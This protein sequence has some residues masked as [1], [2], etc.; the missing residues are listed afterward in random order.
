M[1][2]FLAHSSWAQPSLY[3]RKL[4]TEAEIGATEQ[5]VAAEIARRT[6]PLKQGRPEILALDGRPIDVLEGINRELAKPILDASKRAVMARVEELSKKWVTA[7][8]EEARLRFEENKK[9]G[10]NAQL[11]YDA[12]GIPETELLRANHELAVKALKAAKGKPGV[13]ELEASVAQLAIEALKKSFNARVKAAADE[14]M[15]AAEEKLAES[16]NKILPDWDS[17]VNATSPIVAEFAAQLAR[18]FP[19]ERAQAKKSKSAVEASAVAAEKLPAPVTAQLNPAGVPELVV[20]EIGVRAYYD[21]ELGTVV[22]EST[23]GLMP[24]PDGPVMVVDHGDGT[25]KSNASSW[26]YVLAKF[27]DS[28]WNPIAMNLPKAGV[29]MDITGFYKT[30]AYLDHRYRVVRARTTP[31]DGSAAMPIVL[32]GRSMG[33]AKGYAHALLYDGPANVVDA[34]VLSSFSNPYTMDLQITNV[35]KQVA[36]GNIKG[37]VPEMLEGAKVL[38]QEMLAA[39]EKLKTDDPA[40]FKDFGDNQFYLQGNA[41]E[42][43][44]PSVLVDLKQFTDNFA[45]R[46]HT[47]V[48]ENALL[49]YEIP[50]FAK[51][52]PAQWEGTHNLFS[53][54]QNLTPESLKRSVDGMKARKASGAPGPVLRGRRRDVRFFRLPGHEYVVTP[55]DDPRQKEFPGAAREAHGRQVV[56]G[57]VSREDEDHAGRAA[58]GQGRALFSCRAPE[59]RR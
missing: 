4:L 26:K 13:G 42:D 16:V 8:K 1:A 19:I 43:G 22:L 20:G 33:S 57:V 47:Y 18:D 52:D 3:C 55:R 30:T 51:I 34:Y 32:M 7:S 37:V 38:S 11:T 50:N 48:F 56:P 44:G 40:A 12:D 10:K 39:A 25:I 53:N 31:K 36:L 2:L 41:D 35:E 9:S 28:S 59:A 46:A 27:V 21:V 6:E 45:P 15:D 58:R 49:K 5:G 14:V 24:N 23:K 54:L 17:V 29:G